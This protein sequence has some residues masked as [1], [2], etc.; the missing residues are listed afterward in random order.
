MAGRFFQEWKSYRQ[1]VMPAGISTT[2]ETETRRA[3]YAGAQCLLSLQMNGFETASG[4]I[5]PTEDDLAL[6]DGIKA[7]FDEFLEQIK[8]GKA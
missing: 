5:E 7:E 6:M 4:S 8:T 2:Q 1:R 3:F